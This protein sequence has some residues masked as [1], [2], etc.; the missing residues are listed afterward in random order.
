MAAQSRG[1]ALR[2]VQRSISDE[3]RWSFI[4]GA[5][6]A[7]QLE[8]LNLEPYSKGQMN[9][10][11]GVWH[12]VDQERRIHRLQ[13]PA[14]CARRAGAH[15]AAA[16]LLVHKHVNK[17]Y[18]GFQASSVEP[19]IYTRSC[20]YSS[21]MPRRQWMTTTPCGAFVGNSFVVN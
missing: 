7:P 1:A 2:P 13:A 10:F 9:N 17:A 15:T 16:S 20:P 12:T 21:M 11:L 19:V 14:A 18:S 4:P 6:R 3:A 5:C 8:S